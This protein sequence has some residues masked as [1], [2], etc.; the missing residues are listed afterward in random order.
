MSIQLE[1][2]LT[3]SVFNSV[4]T[5]EKWRSPLGI[6]NGGGFLGIGVALTLQQSR[7]GFDN[8][9]HF[10]LNKRMFKKNDKYKAIQH[11]IQTH[12]S[13]SDVVLLRFQR[14]IQFIS[15]SHDTS[16]IDKRR[17]NEPLTD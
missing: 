9:N 2:N 13:V 7:R 3:I 12:F 6:Q 15:S 16:L 14:L 8:V 11:K 17:V 10:F 1:I 5:V 4:V